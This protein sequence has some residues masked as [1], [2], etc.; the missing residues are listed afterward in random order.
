MASFGYQA[1]ASLMTSTRPCPALISSP[2]AVLSQQTLSFD[3][4]CSCDQFVFS[5][6][7]TWQPIEQ[8]SGMLGGL[9]ALQQ[10]FDAAGTARAAL[11]SQPVR[12]CCSFAQALLN[13]RLQSPD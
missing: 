5:G 6:Y 10:Q 3:L 8:A 7:N 12:I 13:P 9:P 4:C 11:S 1:P 2:A